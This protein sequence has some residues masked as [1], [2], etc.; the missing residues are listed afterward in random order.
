[1]EDDDRDACIAALRVGIDAGLTHIDT[2]ELYG[3]G[4]VEQAIVAPAIE[5]QRHELFLASKL[6]PEHATFDGTIAACERSLGRLR[7]DRLDLYYLH[8]RDSHPLEGTF[9][10]FERLA[11]A[12][13]ILAWGVSNFD[14]GDLDEALAIAPPGRLVADQVLYHLEERAVERM[15]L[16]AC[17]ASSMALVAYSPF[18]HGRL[19]WRH[20]AAGLVLVELAHAH[21][22]T[23]GA[24]VLAFLSQRQSVFVIPKAA[25]AEHARENAA[26]GDLRLSDEELTRIDGAFRAGPLPRELPML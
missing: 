26:A 1:M 2:A 22:T 6:L 10:A 4:Y 3:D 5:G 13:K 25:R 12:G 7:T 8:W 18:G 23:P 24:I 17:E 14:S 16:P 15:V 21:R 11:E 19:P 9:E 20:G